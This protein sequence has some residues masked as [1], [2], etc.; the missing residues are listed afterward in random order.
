MA[1]SDSN[2]AINELCS[3]LAEADP[4]AESAVMG[5]ISRL[6]LDDP[7]EWSMDPTAQSIE[8]L[9]SYLDH[10]DPELRSGAV[11]M[12]STIAAGTLL[13]PDSEDAV[14]RSALSAQ[15]LELIDD[16]SPQVR[17]VIVSTG[18]LGGVVD[19][20]LDD[21]FPTSETDDE[22][23]PPKS[24]SWLAMALFERLHDPAPI[25]RKRVASHLDSHAVELLEEHP[26]ASAAIGTVIDTLEDD[27]D[28]LAPNRDAATPRYAAARVLCDV[29]ANSP[30]LLLDH[31][32]RLD[33][34]LD[35][36]EDEIRTRVARTLGRLIHS[37][38]VD[39]TDVAERVV[40]RLA[41][42]G[43]APQDDADLLASAALAAS[44]ESGKTEA[45]LTA[46]LQVQSPRHR[47]TGA[48]TLARY[49][50]Q[51]DRSFEPHF[52]AVAEYSDARP[53]AER[54]EDPLVTLAAAYP[55]FVAECLIDWHESVVEG[56]A[57]RTIDDDLLVE[58]C[59]QNPTAIEEFLPYVVE[60]A[61]PEFD[62]E[63]SDRHHV[64]PSVQTLDA[65]A[66]RRSAM[67]ADVVPDLLAARGR[68]APLDDRVSS[69]VEAVADVGPPVTD[70]TVAALEGTLRSVEGNLGAARALAALYEAGHDA[71][72]DDYEIFVDPYREGALDGSSNGGK[73]ALQPVAA[74]E[75]AFV[76]E[77][78]YDIFDHW[79]ETDGE[80]GPTR[81]LTAV[82]DAELAAVRP[83]LDDVIAVTLS[84]GPADE[85]IENLS[86]DQLFDLVKFYI[87]GEPPNGPEF[88]ERFLDA[89]VPVVEH[90]STVDKT[91]DEVVGGAEIPGRFDPED[92]VD[93]IDSETTSTP[94]TIESALAPFVDTVVEPLLSPRSAAMDLHLDI[95]KAIGFGHP[96]VFET[97]VQRLLDAAEAADHR[98]QA[99]LVGYMLCELGEETPDTIEEHLDRLSDLAVDGDIASSSIAAGT[100]GKLLEER[101]ERAA[102]VAEPLATALP[103]VYPW[104]R[105]QGA[106]ALETAA[107]EDPQAIRDVV[108]ELVALL[109][110]FDG[111]PDDD[112][113]PW[114]TTR[115]LNGS[116]RYAFMVLESVAETDPESVL[117]AFGSHG[118]IESVEVPGWSNRLSN[119]E[120]TLDA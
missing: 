119:L 40:D 53:F 8:L 49:V 4:T 98:Q 107:E 57:H 9:Q 23:I 21:S 120:A 2:P 110:A 117:V 112:D 113:L 39:R 102:T 111:L 17:Q 30:A 34:Y 73:Y 94:E 61:G 64:S 74:A 104:A 56:S 84:E 87:S 93:L 35:V 106:M 44:D 12:L 36:D 47:S 62:Y 68:S 91:T 10:D 46:G 51:S 50:R 20:V 52:E 7:S 38:H 78:L 103:N 109:V 108:S 90:G 32:D 11:F 70:E 29:A 77:V 116:V 5:Q 3:R 92:I 75:P 63:R 96:V 105:Y 27:L 118:G 48:D 97:H 99:D 95:A 43:R 80:Q 89:L 72:N 88:F 55:G 83:I 76:S 6:Y 31:V 100:L 54:S 37:D 28:A 41:S 115:E 22:R 66:E 59:D 15:L 81:T 33:G 65:L 18:A 86:D 85:R 114:T 60:T 69:L 1:Q 13:E 14:D 42:Q 45:A 101:P 19:T 82:A 67:I 71:V 26:D 79:A 24:I 16:D 58:I 25:V